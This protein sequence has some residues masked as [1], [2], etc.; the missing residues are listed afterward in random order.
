MPKMKFKNVEQ[1]FCVHSYGPEDWD[2]PTRFTF[3]PWCGVRLN[4]TEDK[5]DDCEKGGC[6]D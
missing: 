1:N 3:C 4:Q 2:D 5:K 6:A